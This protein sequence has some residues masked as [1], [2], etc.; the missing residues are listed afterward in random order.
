VLHHYAPHLGV[1]YAAPAGTPVMATG[2]G[3]VIT[4]SRTRANGNYIKIRHNSNYITYY[5]HLSRFAK[6]IRKGVRVKQ[7]QVIGYVGSTGYATGPHLDYRVKKNGRF[8][9]PRTLKLPPARPVRS[10]KRNEFAQLK[11][12][13]IQDLRTI[14]IEDFRTTH[15]ASS[16]SSQDERAN[17]HEVNEPASATQ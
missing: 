17:G 15:Y 7:G 5:L 2:D 8:V 4:A 3:V 9:N 6:G 13:L 14:P 12:K 16:P 11:E 10:E 1:D